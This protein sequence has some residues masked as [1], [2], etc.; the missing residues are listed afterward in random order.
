MR[1]NYQSGLN[2]DLQGYWKD[3]SG[4]YKLILIIRND[5][6]EVDENKRIIYLKDFK[7]SLRF[8]GKLKWHGKQGRLEIIYNEAKRSWYAHIPV[9]VESETKVE[10][11]LRA[12][13]DLGIINLATVYVEDGSWYLFKG[14]SVLSQY[15]YYSKKIRIV[16]KTLA[17]HKQNRSKKLKLLYENRSRFLKHALNS[18][19]RKVVELLKDKRVSEVVIGYPKEINRNHGNKLTVNFWNYRYVIKR[20]EEIGEELGIRVVKVDESYTSKTCSLCGEAHESGRVKRGLFKCPRIGKVINADLN[21]AINILHIPESLGS[22]SGGQ[23]P[24]RDRGNGLKI[25]P[26]VYRWTNG[27]GWVL[28]APTSYEVVRMKVVNHKPMNRPKGT[29]AL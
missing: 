12:S 10:G 14:G 24:V 11:N 3:K 18:M 4:K 23:L 1:E 16:Q 17:R 13:V 26:V 5:R 20:F 27:A 25:Q 15:E 19:V 21:G 7:L 8:K 9:E 2:Q 29:L 6:Y 22:G 28:Y